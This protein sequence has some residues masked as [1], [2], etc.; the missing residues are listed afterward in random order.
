MNP[1]EPGPSGSKKPRISYAGLPVRSYPRTLQRHWTEEE[2]L[3]MLVESDD[4]LEDP[5]YIDMDV[6]DDEHVSSSESDGDIDART[7]ASENL[8]TA[9]D[10]GTDPQELDG[11]VVEENPNILSTLNWSDA[12]NMMTI[13]FTR[14]NELLVPTPAQ[15]TVS[16]PV[17]NV[18][19]IPPFEV[20]NS[21]QEDFR[22]Y[23]ERFENYL[24]MKEFSWKLKDMLDDEGNNSI[25]SQSNINN[26]VR[27]KENATLV[28]A[29]RINKRGGSDEKR[30][31]SKIKKNEDREK[32]I[33]LKSCTDALQ[34]KPTES[35]ALGQYISS[36]LGKVRKAVGGETKQRYLT[37]GGLPKPTLTSED[38]LILGIINKKT[39][40]GF[41]NQ[42]DAD[43]IEASPLEEENKHPP[44]K[45]KLA[46][47]I[48]IVQDDFDDEEI[49]TQ[50]EAST[51][52]PQPNLLQKESHQKSN[53]S[54]SRRRPTTIIKSLTSNEIG[55]KYNNLLDC[56]LA[57]AQAEMT[58]QTEEHKLKR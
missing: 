18:A 43:Q 6:D 10:G 57:I 41:N 12:P 7:S 50:N 14:D 5:S 20:F 53:F 52:R 36:K 1:N 23:V 49:Q 13:P 22:M 37:G 15:A 4:D 19:N 34:S 33:F 30:G 45:V 47:F 31:P 3:Q 40:I 54:A 24:K 42:F 58:W 48:K 35:E 2:L 38:D 11:E 9:E 29:S 44:K 55:E 17:I 51:S 32:Q 8:F 16:N 39:T 26:E 56:K 28:D 25:P 46:E 27:K 21:K